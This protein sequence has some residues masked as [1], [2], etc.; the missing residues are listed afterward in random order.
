MTDIFDNDTLS[1]P[2]P[3]CGKETEQPVGYR[4]RSPDLTC[5]GCGATFKVEGEALGADL[6]SA[7]QGFEDMLKRKSK[8]N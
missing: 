4:K 6:D 3:A 1:V 5:D 8:L 7:V 2:C